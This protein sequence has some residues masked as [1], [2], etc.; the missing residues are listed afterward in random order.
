MYIS[1]YLQWF[2]LC[3]SDTKELSVASTVEKKNSKYTFS[4]VLK[5]VKQSYG[6]L[7]TS[8]FFYLPVIYLLLSQA[9]NSF[10]FDISVTKWFKHVLQNVTLSRCHTILISDMVPFTSSLSPGYHWL[11][12]CFV[13]SLQKTKK[14]SLED[15]GHLI[16]DLMGDFYR[17]LYLR[18]PR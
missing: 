3:F 17:P 18:D 10:Y 8:S 4:N 11:C 12:V 7:I 5:L 16:Q 9:L 1:L 2:L 6:K 15:V 14:F 13:S